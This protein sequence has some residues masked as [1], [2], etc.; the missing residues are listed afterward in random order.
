[1][2]DFDFKAIID[3][4]PYLFLT[5]LKFTLILTFTSIAGGVLFG[6]LLGMAVAGLHGL[7]QSM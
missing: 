1:M 3:A 2:N 6:A 5:G 7:L 4:A